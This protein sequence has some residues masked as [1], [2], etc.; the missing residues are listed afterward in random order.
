MASIVPRPQSGSSRLI[1]QKS[2]R[3]S[4]TESPMLFLNTGKIEHQRKAR[5]ASSFRVMQRNKKNVPWHENERIDVEEKK[6]TSTRQEATGT[7]KNSCR[8]ELT[9]RREPSEDN[10]VKTVCWL[11]G[12]GQGH[13]PVGSCWQ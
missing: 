10:A 1:S 8:A 12:T 7:S 11:A 2:G 6:R 9:R 5:G 13:C 4:N 3:R